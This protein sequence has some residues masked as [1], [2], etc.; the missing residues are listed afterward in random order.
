MSGRA[1]AA[2]LVLL[3][4]A[5]V[6][7]V[8]ISIA[9]STRSAA[10]VPAGD[11]APVRLTTNPSSPYIIVRT[12]EDKA[13]WNHVALVPLDALGGPRFVTPL[14]CERVHFAGGVGV[15]L[16]SAAAAT[17][18]SYSVSIFDGQFA[19]TA[20]FPLTGVPSRA[21]MSRNGSFAAVTVFESG[22]SYASGTFSTRTSIFDTTARKSLGDLEQFE[23]TRDGRV[24]R[25]ADFNYWGVTFAGDNDT[26][27]ATLAT[28]GTKYLVEGRVSSRRLHV[29]RPDVECPSLSPDGTRIVYK[30]ANGRSGWG[31]RVLVLATGDDRALAA[32]SRSVDDQVEWLDDNHVLYHQTGAGGADLW[33]MDL[34]GGAPRFFMAGAYSPAV[35]R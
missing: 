15:C 23:L 32:E 5:G 7:A 10:A 25:A 11:P 26:F 1:K 12:F 13:S 6:T 20:R 30:R 28:G 17:A 24:F 35:V 4:A 16:S 19:E 3:A 22:H 21:R 18:M 27:F 2:I 31:L 9:S 33:V 34:A 8:W 29:V 14:E